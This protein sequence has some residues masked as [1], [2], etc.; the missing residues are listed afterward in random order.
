M[1]NIKQRQMETNEAIDIKT[2]FGIGFDFD[3][4]VLANGEY[5]THA[6]AQQWLMQAPYVICCDGAANEYLRRG[7][8]PDAIIGDGD[9][10][11]PENR[12][13]FAA[14]FH[15]VADQETN[16]QTKAIHFLRTQG[17]RRILIVGATGRREDHTL[18]NISL[19]VDYRQ[20][21]IDV[22]MATN[23]GLFTPAQGDCTFASHHGQQ[24]SIFNFGAQGLQA[25]GLVYPLSDFTHW[26]QGTL[27]E[28][29]G[30]E[31]TIRA[32]GDYLVFQ[33]Y[34]GSV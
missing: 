23:Y 25:E 10:I 8:T 2:G 15:P 34:E 6:F 7:F 5:P 22:R 19:L 9:S 20:A 27:N 1:T 32:T 21:G 24:V 29:I 12:E 14:L 18:G 31:F 11:S 28:A 16:D 33:T 26:W 30:T 17:K 13:R 3:A 4:V